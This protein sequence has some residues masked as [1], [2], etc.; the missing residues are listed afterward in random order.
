MVNTAV[1]LLGSNE[2]DREKN[3]MSAIDLLKSEVG[4]VS[5]FSSVYETA[6]WGNTDQPAFLN[7]II[8]METLLSATMLMKIILGIEKKAGRIRREK[9]AQ[10]II[11]ID[12]LFF[13]DEIINEEHL[14]IPHR[15][16]HERKF[17]LVPLMEIMPGFIHPVFLKPVSELFRQLKDT[18]DV[19]LHAVERAGREVVSPSK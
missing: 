16:L 17:V 13:N 8:V 14:H 19:R 1:L 2:G 4:K 6:P 18:S 10:R 5:K 3:L 7:G 11:D 9:W 12:I 15:H